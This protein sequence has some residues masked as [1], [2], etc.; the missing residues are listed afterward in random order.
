MKKLKHNPLITIG[1]PVYNASE[2]IEL[3]IGSILNQ[4]FTD[5]E[6]IIIDDGSTDNTV[7]I[8]KRIEDPRIILMVD[9][10][11]KGISYRLNQLIGEA[12]GRYFARMDGDDIM[13]PDR[14]LKQFRYLE[15][16]PKVNVLGSSAVIID[17]ENR[18]IGQRIAS[19]RVTLSMI[20]DSP[21][22]IHPSIMGR[23][24]W[25]QNYKYTESLS[26]VE[27]Y[28]LWLRG[29]TPEGYEI[30]DEPLIYYRD[31]LVFRLK[32]YRFRSRQMRK[33]FK[34]HKVFG[35]SKYYAKIVLSYIK[36]YLAVIFTNLH[37]D[38]FWI[39]KRNQSLDSD[40]LFKYR[41]LLQNIIAKSYFG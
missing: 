9:D 37:I 15:Q 5:F 14:L 2:F 18:I 3:S 35:G 4:S 29:F 32:T 13:M 34:R 20:K 10:Q 8:I 41:E 21:T 26:G 36:E 39:K 11:N 24:S 28:D 6:L 38:K 22:F 23:T 19:G 25:F 40:S 31:P 12:R 7:D 33:M 1:L 30:Y 27:D 16:H 17:A